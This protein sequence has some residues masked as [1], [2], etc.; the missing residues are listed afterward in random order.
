MLTDKF[1]I[2]ENRY[3]SSQVTEVGVSVRRSVFCVN[4]VV[5]ELS[6]VSDYNCGKR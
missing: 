6:F 2:S 1:Y 5:K 3:S 4:F